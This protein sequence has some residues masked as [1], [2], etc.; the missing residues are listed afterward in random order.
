[1]NFKEKET[2]GAA[3]VMSHVVY[4]STLFATS[5][6]VISKLALKLKLFKLFVPYQYNMEILI[7]FAIIL[8]EETT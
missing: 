8:S 5:N 3:P 7:L 2:L 6:N 1:M 4:F